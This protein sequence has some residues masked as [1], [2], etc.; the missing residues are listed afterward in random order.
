MRKLVM[1]TFFFSFLY[2]LS[3]KI[4]LELRNLLINQ[5]R[6]KDFWNKIL[7]TYLCVMCQGKKRKKEVEGQ[8][9]RE[10][11]SEDVLR[12]WVAQVCI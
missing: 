4:L 1:K 12:K 10:R 7:V 9:E 3:S 5:K 2:F 8:R 11:T 6:K